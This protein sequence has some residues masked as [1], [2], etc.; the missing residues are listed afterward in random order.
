[1][2][3]KETHSYVSSSGVKEIA[4]LGG[5]PSEFV[6]AQVR[7]ALARKYAERKAQGDR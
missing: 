7:D 6:P 5:D 1:M 2:M 3:P 4:M